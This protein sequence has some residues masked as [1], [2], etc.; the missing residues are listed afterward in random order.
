M[1]LLALLKGDRWQATCD[2]RWE[3][4]DTWKVTGAKWQVTGGWWL[5]SLA[6]TDFRL[7]KQEQLD[8]SELR[9]VGNRIEVSRHSMAKLNKMKADK[10]M[11]P[12][13][14]EVVADNIKMEAPDEISIDKEKNNF[15]KKINTE[16]CQC[17]GRPK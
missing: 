6:K 7:G 2:I 13:K 3:T 1:W 10:Y 5:N 9:R 12:I 4:S 8:K 17:D 16:V 14:R 15:K 11:D